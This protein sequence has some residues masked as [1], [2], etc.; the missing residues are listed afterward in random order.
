MRWIAIALLV[1]ACGSNTPA[2][3]DDDGPD[4]ATVDEDSAY[5][6]DY[7]KLHTFE[8]ELSDADWTWLQANPLLEEYRP[9]EVVFEGRR[10]TGAALRYKGSYCTLESCVDAD[11]GER[12][13]PKLSFK[14]KFNEYDA[15][16]R[17][18]GLRKFNLHSGVRDQTMMHEV[19]SYHLY[20]SL[21]VPAP[22]ASHALVTINGEPQGLFVLIEDIDKEFLQ[23]QWTDDEGNLYKSVWPQHGDAA[24]Y[25]EALE[26]NETTGDVSRMLALHTA[27]EAANDATFAA[28]M[29]PYVDLQAMARF[30]AVDRAVGNDDGMKGFYCYN[31]DDTAADCENANY[32][33]YEVP[34][35]KSQLIAWDTDY[36]LGDVNQ[37]LGRSYWEENPDGCALISF[38]DFWNEDPC[39]TDSVW[40]VPP[41]CNKFYGLLHRA[42]WNDYRTALAELVAGPMS[43]A[44]LTPMIDGIR[45][46]LRPAIDADERGPGIL[47]W[48][49]SLD[50][51]MEVL[52][53]QRAA[54]QTLLDEPPL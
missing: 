36:T 43:A 25:Q 29:V 7:T 42:T 31:A 20:R 32:F 50:W 15:D 1:A 4:A 17:F 37:D 51:M 3:D 13:C 24:S 39:S 33:W 16:G 49:D 10:W 45:D 53:G 30:I 27:I 12:L 22:R 28:D 47:D 21:G 41:Q 14:L 54:I 2:D 38:C 8:I 52:N 40:L 48:E 34:G 6:F 23:D 35:G 46:K 26:T 11:T 44:E 5:L 19:V 18:Y 9:A